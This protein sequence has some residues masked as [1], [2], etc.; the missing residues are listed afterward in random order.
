MLK[1]LRKVLCVPLDTRIDQK[2]TAMKSSRCLQKV[3]R[4]LIKEKGTPPEK[5]N[6]EGYQTP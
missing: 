4:V 1:W 3:L 6:V 2:Y 5:G